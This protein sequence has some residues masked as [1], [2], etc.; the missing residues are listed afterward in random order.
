M[1]TPHK[2]PQKHNRISHVSAMSSL[3]EVL[4][5]SIVT[6]RGSRLLDGNPLRQSDIGWGRQ[7]LKN[8]A[9]NPKPVV[10]EASPRKGFTILCHIPCYHIYNDLFNHN[11]NDTRNE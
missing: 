6:R 11:I 9:R 2:L 1:A 10:E 5:I 8:A 4:L 7:S 3:Y